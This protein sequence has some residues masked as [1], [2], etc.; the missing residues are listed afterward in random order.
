MPGESPPFRSLLYAEPRLYDLVFPDADAGLARLCRAA[1]ARHLPAPPRSVLDIGCGTGRTL[2]TLAPQVAECWGVDLLESNVAY[3]RATRPGLAIRQGDM[4]TVR[5]GRTFDAVTSFGNV[6]AYALT[7]ADLARTVT[8]YAAHAHA[9]TLLVVDALNARAYLDG[10]GFRER[11]ERRVETPELTATA[12]AVHTLD[13]AARRLTRTRVWR[14]AG[15]EDVEDYAE[16]R[17][18]DPDELAGL[19]EAGGF[20]VLGLFDNREL[21]PSPLTGR[22]DVPDDPGGMAG[23]KL[24]AIARKIGALTP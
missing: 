14:I 5:L 13:R 11:I 6:L 12:V 24:Y 10:G 15:R 7:D 23:R 1:F 20:T 18:L 22:A 19:L 9:G 17:L 21:R 16:Y 8:T 2:E 4:R 3:A